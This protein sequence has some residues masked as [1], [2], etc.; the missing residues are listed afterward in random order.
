MQTTLPEQRIFL[1]AKYANSLLCLSLVFL[2]LQAASVSASRAAPG[3]KQYIF[4][5]SSNQTSSNILGFTGV[6]AYVNFPDR[7]QKCGI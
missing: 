6:P 4:S 1:G 5:R 3:P 2:W 7:T